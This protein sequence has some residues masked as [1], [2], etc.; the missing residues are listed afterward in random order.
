LAEEKE[1][2]KEQKRRNGARFYSKFEIL[3]LCLKPSKMAL[4]ASQAVV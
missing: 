3:S 4:L 1:K 2:I